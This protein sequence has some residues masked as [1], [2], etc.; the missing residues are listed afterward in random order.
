MD[1]L[2]IYVGFSFKSIVHVQYFN[3]SGRVSK[4]CPIQATTRVYIAAMQL[5]IVSQEDQDQ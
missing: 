1:M 3:I 4:T 5:L 2:Q